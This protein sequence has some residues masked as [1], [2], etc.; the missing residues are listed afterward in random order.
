[1]NLIKCDNRWISRISVERAMLLLS[2]CFDEIFIL[3]K[4]K[5]ESITVDFEDIIVK[6]ETNDLVWCVEKIYTKRA[7][8]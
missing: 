5:W 1:M 6:T 4:N 7:L 8:Y 2:K 3:V